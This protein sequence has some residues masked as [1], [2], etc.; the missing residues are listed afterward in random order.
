MFKLARIWKAS[1]SISPCNDIIK[2]DNS[3]A[4][5]PLDKAEALGSFWSGTFS[6]IGKNRRRTHDFLK[7]NC[8]PWSFSDSSPPS[9]I[10]Y[11]IILDRVAGY[12]V[13]PDG[14]PYNASSSNKVLPSAQVWWLFKLWCLPSSRI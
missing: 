14:L 4:S 1:N 10:V 3:I 6:K 2:T 13:G 5:S 8:S 11:E 12:G 7:R 9:P